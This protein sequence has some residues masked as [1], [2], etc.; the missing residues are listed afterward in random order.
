MKINMKELSKFIKWSVCGDGYVGY[1]THNK[2]AHYSI[3]RL[4]EHEDYILTIADKF[5]GLQDCDV[6]ITKSTRKDNGKTMIRLNTSS[7]PIFSRIRERQYIKGH[8]VIDP[9][10]LTVVDW[11]AL[12]FLYQDDGSLCYNSKGG[13]IVRLSTCS[14]SYH[15]QLALRHTFLDKFNLCFNVNKAGKGLYQLNLAKKDQAKFFD[16]IFPYM[17]WSYFYKLPESLQNG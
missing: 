2:V 1:A 8:R 6:N 10:M 17:V 4:I 14:Y 12:A 15:E 5:K 13:S 3:E 11:E 9:H 7:H 16:G